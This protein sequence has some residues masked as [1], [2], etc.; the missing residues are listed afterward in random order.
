MRTQTKK[1][2]GLFGL[3]LVAAMTV[4]AATLPV[5]EATAVSTVTDTIVVRVIGETP[6][7]EFTGVSSDETF[8][9]PNQTFSYIYD[10]TKTVTITLEYTDLDGNT[11][12]YIL[13]TIDADYNVGS[14]TLDL[15]LAGPNYGFGDY[16]LTIS[17]DHQSAL[18]DEDA[19]KFSYYPFTATV[20]E[21]D[22]SDNATLTLDYDEDE[23]D[24]DKLEVE[25]RDENGNIV[26]GIP[27]ITITP[28]EKEIEIP[29]ADNHLP[30]GTYTVTITAYDDN[31]D[32]LYTKTITYVYEPTLVPNTG[33]VFA[34]LNI[35]K[36][37]Y[38]ITGL[39]IFFV[40]GIAGLAFVA[41]KNKSTRKRR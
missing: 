31:G 19:I 41:K 36:S 34:G 23:T 7:V 10:N 27:P 18:P 40:V 1:A 33:S 14:G 32:V 37:D 21:S 2:F 16:V 12:E 6:H 13:E 5:P 28:P 8:T 24:I 26:P 4:F 9:T 29:L 17:G 30:A 25:V 35:S 15:N 38:L 22:D 11:H 20:T 3:L 39:F